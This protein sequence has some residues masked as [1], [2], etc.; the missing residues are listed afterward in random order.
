MQT[1]LRILRKTEIGQERQKQTIAKE[2]IE[3]NLW[4]MKR[5]IPLEG[6]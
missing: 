3:G 4:G 2:M 5:L 6:V 1:K